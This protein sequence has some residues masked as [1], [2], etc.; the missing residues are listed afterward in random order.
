[1]K[2]C[3][4]C[5]ITKPLT[6]FCKNKNSVDGHEHS[7]K[8]CRKAYRQK[9]KETLVPTLPDVKECSCCGAVKPASEFRS[10]NLHSTGLAS[11]CKECEAEQYARYCKTEKGKAYMRAKKYRHNQYGYEP[12]NEDVTG[13]HF[14]HLHL[15]DNHAFGIFV[16]DFIHN[17]LYHNSFTWENM[18]TVNAR[19]IQY[20]LDSEMFND[21]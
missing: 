17:D 13:F 3:T 16:P 18:D 11:A 10:H 21:E 6:D 20:W 1:M 9:R 12:L 2:T 7:C 19:A 14:H 8:E 5:K 4:R 15:E